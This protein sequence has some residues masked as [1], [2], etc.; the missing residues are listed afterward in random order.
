[1]YFRAIE[2]MP[3]PA[4]RTNPVPHAAFC[5]FSY[6]IFA[7]EICAVVIPAFFNWASAGAQ[8]LSGGSGSGGGGPQYCS[9]YWWI[10]DP[11]SV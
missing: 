8:P 1:M 9:M 3:I 6:V 4:S 2:A 11:W 5:V 7:L 10:C